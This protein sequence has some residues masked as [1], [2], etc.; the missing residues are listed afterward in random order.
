MSIIQFDPA[1]DPDHVLEE[2]KGTFR[3]CFV[4]GYDHDDEL[5]VMGTSQLSVA[6]VLYMLE[7]Y[8]LGLLMDDDEG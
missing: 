1:A 7:S 2:A 5:M 8:K 4:L 6:D 3:E